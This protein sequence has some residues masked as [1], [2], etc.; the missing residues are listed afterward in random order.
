LSKRREKPERSG[1]RLHDFFTC[2]RE[3]SNLCPWF[4]RPVLYPLSYGGSDPS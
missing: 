1:G 2:P 4:R 3:D